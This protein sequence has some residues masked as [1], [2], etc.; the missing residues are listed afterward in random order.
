MKINFRE[1]FRRIFNF[2][3]N[4]K[5]CEREPCHKEAQFSLQ[6]VKDSSDLDNDTNIKT[7][8]GSSQEPLIK[9]SICLK[10]STT[11]SQESQ[12]NMRSRE[13]LTKIETFSAKSTVRAKLRRGRKVQ[14]SKLPIPTKC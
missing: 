13:K 12:S 5:P 6:M 7:D 3:Y 9:E 14:G 10:P 1:T 4:P 11:S 2:F 8:S